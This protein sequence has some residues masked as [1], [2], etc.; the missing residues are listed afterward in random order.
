MNVIFILV[1]GTEATYLDEG[2]SSNLPQRL[3]FSWT[4]K[5]YVACYFDGGNI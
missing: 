5:A 4:K 1:L 3:I 2:S